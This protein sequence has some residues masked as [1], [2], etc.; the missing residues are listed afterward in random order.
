[1]APMPRTAP[2]ASWSLFGMPRI[3]ARE[4]PLMGWRFVAI[5]VLPSLAFPLIA[6]WLAKLYSH[7]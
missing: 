4:A 5:R 1:M 7:E 6:G 2:F 3:I